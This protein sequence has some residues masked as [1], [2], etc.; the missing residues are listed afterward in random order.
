VKWGEVRAGDVFVTNYGAASPMVDD[1]WVVLGVRPSEEGELFVVI[2]YA[3]LHN[4]DVSEWNAIA[5]QQTSEYT[6]IR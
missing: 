6:L 3:Y 4:M 1:V 5:E 2:R